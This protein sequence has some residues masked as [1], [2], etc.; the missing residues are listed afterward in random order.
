MFINV[1]A[2]IIIEL[3]QDAGYKA[4]LVGGCVRD[5]YMGIAPKDWDICTSAT[6][7]EMRKV[8]KDYKIYNTGEK[9]GTLTVNVNNELF[10]VTTFRKD[11]Q[12][13]DARHPDSVEFINDIKGDLARRDFTINAIA[14]NYQ[15]NHVDPFDG[16][17]DIC[18]NIIRCVGDPEERFKEDALRILRALRFA[19]R[20]GFKIEDKTL[21]A[22][23]NLT[24]SGALHKIA[25]ERIRE[26]LIKII[27]APYAYDI[28][29]QY[30][31]IICNVIPY[32]GEC[33]G[34]NQNNKYHSFDVY[35]HSLQALK[36]YI[37][38]GGSDVNIKIALLL[39]DI[40]KPDCY[41]EDENGGHFYGHPEVSKKKAEYIFN[42]LRFSNKDKEDLLMLIENHDIHIE[43]TKRCVHKAVCKFGPENLHRLFQMQKADILAHSPLNRDNRYEKILKKEEF[44]KEIVEEDACFSL[45][46]LAIN[47]TDI[48]KAGIPQGKM[49]GETLNF[50]LRA[51]MD[52]CS[53][54]RVTLLNLVKEYKE[55]IHAPKYVN[56]GDG[57]K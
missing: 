12:Y 52:G 7:D 4:Y 57:A 39:H 29:H 17:K 34:F 31:G 44:L 42:V 38:N 32:L 3:L 28:L 2:N 19:A 40:G 35:E 1:N 30:Y 41:T 50:L 54:D 27:D 22:M 48:I 9:H 53:N 13:S 43:P 10:E 55:Y 6:P 18:S 14:Y 5:A 46:D 16:C 37:D 36:H 51:V 33:V 25:K 45:K 21:S 26:E 49:V 20:Y 23:Y 11:G 8:F 56:T 15:E 47:G 24:L